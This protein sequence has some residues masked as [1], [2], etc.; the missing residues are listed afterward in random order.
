MPNECPRIESCCDGSVYSYSLTTDCSLPIEY[1]NTPQTAEC[2]E[3][4]L[5][6]PYTTPANTF[7]S[8]ISQEDANVKALTYAIE[9]LSCVPIP[10]SCS[11]CDMTI[12]DFVNTYRFIQTPTGSLPVSWNNTDLTQ[13]VNIGNWLVD[14]DGTYNYVHADIFSPNWNPC[15]FQ[16]LLIFKDVIRSKFKLTLDYYDTDFL[17]GTIYNRIGIFQT[18]N[19][20][21]FIPPDCYSCPSPTTTNYPFIFGSYTRDIRNYQLD[22]LSDLSICDSGCPQ[23]NGVFDAPYVDPINVWTTRIYTKDSNGLR[24]Q[25]PENG[26]D[27]GYIPYCGFDYVSGYIGIVGQSYSLRYKNIV[28][29]D[30]P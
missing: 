24:I 30:V 26:Y 28:L 2:P 5:G 3:G 8:F 17:H 19:P 22:P 18:T 16:D 6:D 29:E 23:M 21:D 27:S 9:Q 12:T 10:P 15:A 25:E 13:F 4:T 1:F 20:L 11:P 14:N 7:S